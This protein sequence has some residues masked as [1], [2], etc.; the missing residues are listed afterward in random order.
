MHNRQP[1]PASPLVKGRSN[2][3]L[4]PLYQ[5]GGAE[6]KIERGS[7]VKIMGKLYNHAEY[8]DRRRDLRKSQTD[9]EQILWSKLRNKQ[10][11]GHKFYRQYS[12]G[13]YI[14]DFYCPK[15]KLSIELDGSQ[16]AENKEYD[17]IRTT[18]LENYSI[19]ELRFWNNEVLENLEGVY[20]KILKHL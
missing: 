1:L 18:Y 4:P 17:Q 3:S 10:C 6:G 9:C 8:K 5:R 12:I 16:H 7:C 2:R 11:N 19:R 15:I 13:P 20:E 14:L